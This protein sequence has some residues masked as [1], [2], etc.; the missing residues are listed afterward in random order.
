MVYQFEEQFEQFKQFQQ[1]QFAQFQQF[2]EMQIKNW[3]EVRRQGENT[4]ENSYQPTPIQFPIQSQPQQLPQTNQLFPRRNR[5]NDRRC[6]RLF[7]K[8]PHLHPT[9]KLAKKEP[10]EE[11][12][13][14]VWEDLLHFLF[15]DS[16]PNAHQK[17]NIENKP[18]ERK[19]IDFANNT[20]RQRVA[21]VHWEDIANLFHPS[22]IS[23][24]VKKENPNYK[25][26]KIERKNT[27][28]LQQERDETDKLSNNDNL[29]W[30]DVIKSLLFGNN[31]VPSED[32]KIPVKNDINPP[33]RQTGRSAH[34]ELPQ[35][36][37]KNDSKPTQIPVEQPKPQKQSQPETPEEKLNKFVSKY[38][39]V[40]S[41]DS[42]P[43]KQKEAELMQLLLAV[44]DLHCTPELRPIRK[45][46]VRKINASIEKLALKE[47]QKNTQP[48]NETNEQPES[49][50]NT[51][52]S[53]D[54]IVESESN[55]Q[56]SNDTVNE[57]SDSD[58]TPV[59]YRNGNETISVKTPEEILEESSQPPFDVKES[60]IYDSDAHL[61]KDDLKSEWVKDQSD[62]I[63]AS[64]DEQL[65]N[66][67]QKSKK[68]DTPSSEPSSV[69]DESEIEVTTDSGHEKICVGDV[70]I[71]DVEDE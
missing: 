18:Q 27:P 38:D 16:F 19:K 13:P 52:E 54:N 58:E 28:P 68:I 26:N 34:N 10:E 37:N 53:V 66:K 4:F 24:P 70:V 31:D 20:E 5:Q 36:K 7:N 35:E 46:L 22:S 8:Y 59:E 41:D 15:P 32:E 33:Q 25:E 50:E 48:S 2:Q 6:H 29:T 47:T 62:S 67:N 65:N 60:V 17:T 51:I 39:A 21:P 11:P 14:V 55:V 44:D 63:A 42:I 40:V 43:I 3:L 23:S 56:Q 30:E 1:Q 69:V 64:I 9:Q 71:E 12:T 49:G 61:Q 57:K 45:D